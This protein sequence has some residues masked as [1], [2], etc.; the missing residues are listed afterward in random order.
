MTLGPKAYKT[1]PFPLPLPPAHARGVAAIW[2]HSS[3]Y[4]FAQ[5]GYCVVGSAGQL[6]P[7][8]NRSVRETTG[9]DRN[10]A[11]ST[12]RE[13]LAR[14]PIPQPFSS[15]VRSAVGSA[16]N[17]RDRLQRSLPW[18]PG[19]GLTVVSRAV[20]GYMTSQNLRPPFLSSTW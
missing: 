19:S 5:A 12:A 2:A 1:G 7:R 8:E 3:A 13:N 9:I 16:F 14:I 17:H 10:G 20:D 6:L 4:L 15:G 11:G 18:P